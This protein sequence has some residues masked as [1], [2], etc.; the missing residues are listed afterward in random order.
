MQ[1][2]TTSSIGDQELDILG[3]VKG[4]AGDSPDALT[5]AINN[6]IKEATTLEADA[7]IGIQFSAIPSQPTNLQTLAYGTAVKFRASTSLQQF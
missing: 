2:V 3:L 6:M 4:T 5:L 1:L 7:I